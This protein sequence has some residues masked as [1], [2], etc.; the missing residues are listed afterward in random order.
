[1]ASMKKTTIL[2]CC[3]LL[4]LFSCTKPSG[5]EVTQYYDVPGPYSR[6]Y[7]GDGMNVTVSND[8]EEI[9]ITADENVMEKVKVHLSGGQ[10][11]IERKDFSAFRLMKAEVLLPY[12]EDLRD[13]EASMYASFTTSH[14]IEASDV[15]LTASSFSKVDINY[16]MANNLTINA[17]NYSDVLADITVYNT[18]KLDLEHSDA[19]ITGST[20]NL[21]LKMTSNSEL[22]KHWGNGGYYDFDCSYAYGSMSNSCKAYF[23]CYEEIEIKLT[24]NSELHCTG[25]PYYDECE[26]DDT[27][28]IVFD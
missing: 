20:E 2:F 27:S 9:V 26:W 23:H 21:R 8:V 13:I 25:N 10:L 1:M 18:T 14:G 19:D 28:A 12:N 7:V 11:R 15:S 6:L 24:N 22:K 16:I 4:A 17:E 5:V 3:A